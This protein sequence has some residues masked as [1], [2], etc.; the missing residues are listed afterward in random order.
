MQHSE[1]ND[2][3]TIIIGGNTRCSNVEIPIPHESSL[4]RG[5]FPRYLNEIEEGTCPI[6]LRA[7]HPNG[8]RIPTGEPI[9]S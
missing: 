9:E 3:M 7:I 4:I 6:S 1:N 8:L 5:T 2:V